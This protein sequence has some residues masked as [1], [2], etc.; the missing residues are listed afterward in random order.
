MTRPVPG[1]ADLLLTSCFPPVNGGIARWM[2]EI[3]GRYPDPGLVVSTGQHPDS[4]EVDEPL[5]C[6]V[7]RLPIATRRLRGL[8]GLLLWSRRP[9]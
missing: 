3:A 8:Q 9:R 1:G 2:A 7:D 6:E 4:Q 5:P